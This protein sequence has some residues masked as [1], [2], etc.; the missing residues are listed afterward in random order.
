[1]QEDDSRD[2]GEG[3]GCRGAQ[4]AIGWMLAFPGAGM[5]W[6]ARVILLVLFGIAM[7]VLEVNAFSGPW[8]WRPGQLLFVAVAVAIVAAWI[9]RRRARR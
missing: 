4:D 3:K 8:I 9:V 5:G 7:V 2:D 1:M 6:V